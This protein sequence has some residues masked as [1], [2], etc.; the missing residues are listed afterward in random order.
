MQKYM[1]QNF[2]FYFLTWSKENFQFHWNFQNKN[3]TWLNNSEEN[4]Y[5]YLKLIYFLIKIKY[6]KSEDILS[7]YLKL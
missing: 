5:L 7:Y 6:Y 3:F 2:S 4:D 1:L